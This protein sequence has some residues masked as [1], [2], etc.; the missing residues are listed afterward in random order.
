[1]AQAF[2]RS[3]VVLHAID[4]KGIRGDADAENGIQHQSNEGLYILANP[5]GGTVLKNANSIDADFGRFLKRQ[6]V[7]YVLAFQAPTSE[8]GKFHN[9]KVKLVNVPGGRVSA[10]AGY[11]EAGGENVAERSLSTA[12]VVVNDIPQDAVHFAALIAPFP[13]S[14]EN[15]QVPVVLEI[16]GPDL[17]DGVKG[18]TL[19]AE[20]FAY[21]FD[22]EGL[23]RDS[24][25]QRI[26]LDLTKVGT[27][28]RASGIKFY[29]VLSLP[30]GSYAVKTLVRV[31]ETDRKGFRRTDIVV[32]RHSDV[33]L[34]KPFF[35]EPPGK[36]LM[37]KGASHDKTNAAYPFEVNGDMFI[38]RAGVRVKSGE[39]SKFA[40]F[41]Q[42]AAPDDVTCGDDS[43]CKSAFPIQECERDEAR[44]AARQ[45]R[46]RCVIRERHRSY[47]ERHRSADIHDSDPRRMSLEVIPCPFD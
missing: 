6:E 21:A 15:A 5:T 46:R 14:S 42:N 31:M 33:A 26:G 34:S 11:Y 39:P 37:I 10:R 3:D 1:M 13:T 20:V 47:E 19:T 2:R 7:V 44:H 38:P 23:A 9:L 32:P 45:R 35:Y 18:K 28:L 16:N 43:R 24:L 12:E 36:W 40:V 30:P 4:I 27:T 25:Y 17:I 8:P 29:G 22:D 41:V